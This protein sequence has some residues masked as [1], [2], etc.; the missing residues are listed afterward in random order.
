MKLV[1][2]RGKGRT[3]A[4]LPEWRAQSAIGRATSAARLRGGFRNCKQRYCAVI[5]T[6]RQALNVPVTAL[7]L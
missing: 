7:W 4:D 2:R 6:T 5:R 1:G 3:A